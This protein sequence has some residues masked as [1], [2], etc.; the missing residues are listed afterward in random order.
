LHNGQPADSLPAIELTSDLSK[1][2]Y[3]KIKRLPNRN[4]RNPAIRGSV[5]IVSRNAFWRCLMHPSLVILSQ[6]HPA[7]LEDMP[8]FELHLSLMLA[9]RLLSMLTIP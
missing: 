2:K 1:F 3:Q 7:A 8:A 4:L 6:E 5:S 9:G